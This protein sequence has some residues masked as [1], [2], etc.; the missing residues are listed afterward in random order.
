M[1]D[2]R[3]GQRTVMDVAS[4]IIGPV[5]RLAYVLARYGTDQFVVCCTCGVDDIDRVRDAVRRPSYSWTIA[6]HDLRNA[7]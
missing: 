7:K 6:A 3:T 1:Q 5:L 4:Q 2:I